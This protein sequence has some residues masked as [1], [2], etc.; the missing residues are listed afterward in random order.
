MTGK[1]D[2]A[3]SVVAGFLQPTRSKAWRSQSLII[4]QKETTGS[5]PATNST[6]AF[7]A[8]TLRTASLRQTENESSKETR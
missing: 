7:K 8:D 5:D 4:E 1:E 3:P 6:H 2:K